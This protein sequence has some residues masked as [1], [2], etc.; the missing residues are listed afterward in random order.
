MTLRTAMLLLALLGGSSFAQDDNL[1]EAIE[2]A[3][4]LSVTEAVPASQPAIDALMKRLDEATPRQRVEIRLLHIR[5]LALQGDYGKAIDQ[6][7]ELLGN[8]ISDDQRLRALRLAANLG[9][10]VGQHEWGFAQLKSALE[11]SGE[12]DDLVERSRILSLAGFVHSIVG[13]HERAIDYA[14]QSMTIAGQSGDKSQQCQAGQR[15]A[16][17]YRYAERYEEAQ[18]A[19]RNALSL[20]LDVNDQV[21]TGTSELE[22][23]HLALERGD[24]AAARR[25]TDRGLERLRQAGWADG[26]LTGEHLQAQ[27]AAER[28]ESKQAI[29]LAQVLI[30]RTDER[31]LW[32]RKSELHRLVAEQQAKR[33]EFAEAY[34]HMVAH[35]EARDRFIDEDRSRRLAILE[36]EFDM[37]RQEQELELL[38][39]QKRVAELEAQS[40]RQ[41]ARVRWM[42]TGF[43]VFLFLILVLLLIHVLRERRHYRRL[44]ELDGLTRVSNHTRFFD[45]AR[46]LVEESHRRSQPLVLA[47]GDIDHFKQVNDEHGHI[48]GDKALRQVARVLCENFPGLGHVGRIGGEEFAVC[49][50]DSQLEPV[51]ERLEQVRNDLAEIQYGGNEKPLTMS[52]GVAEL[53]PDEALESLRKRADEALY[54]AKGGGRNSVVV[55][56]PQRVD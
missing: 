13:D 1:G 53:A 8:P 9:I 56:E 47:L 52:F 42:A 45:T 3:R 6:I 24:L 19:A 35:S 54:R 26:V 5:N 28:G 22:L 38:R 43:A 17:A 49:I 18:V 2:R 44:S 39:E 7:K 48:A 25:W 37:Q 32:H 11:L 34:R 12:S 15:L 31:E 30:E 33:E 4:H 23:G 46:M 41:Q 14:T 36:V 29:E 20:C 40:R 16:V 27:L 55:A 50:P 10:N 21:Y 51:L